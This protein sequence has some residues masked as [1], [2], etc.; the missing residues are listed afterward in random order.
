MAKTVAK[1]VRYSGSL[2]GTGTDKGYKGSTADTTKTNPPKGT[3]VTKN[4]STG[5]TTVA[6]NKSAKPTPKPKVNYGAGTNRA[7][8]GSVKAHPLPADVSPGKL[9]VSD[10]ARAKTYL[11]RLSGAALG[12]KRTAAEE[13]TFQKYTGRAKSYAARIDKRTADRKK[14]AKRNA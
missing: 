14:L 7:A 10:V 12:R 6:T 9:D 13:A 3:T 5:R 2:F 1:T 8:G 11:K 4:E